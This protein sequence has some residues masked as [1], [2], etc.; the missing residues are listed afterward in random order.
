[1][2]KPEYSLRRVWLLVK[3]GF[4]WAAGF[5]MVSGLQALGPSDLL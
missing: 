2:Q 5:M 4:L 1:M 3:D